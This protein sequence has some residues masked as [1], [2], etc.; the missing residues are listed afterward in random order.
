MGS[1]IDVDFAGIILPY[2]FC[3]LEPLI[4]SMLGWLGGY[5]G[6]AISNSKN[7]I[8]VG[9]ILVGILT[10]IILMPLPIFS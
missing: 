3:L 7:G 10:A 8:Y 4:G 2:F 9:G 5:I 1:S 6:F